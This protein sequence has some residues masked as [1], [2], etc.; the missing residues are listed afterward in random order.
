MGSGIFSAGCFL[1][2]WKCYT[3]KSFQ[4]FLSIP[5]SLTILQGNESS[6]KVKTGLL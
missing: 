1:G 3:L 4:G 5:G 6:R 2:F